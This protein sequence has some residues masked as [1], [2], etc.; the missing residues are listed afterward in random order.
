LTAYVEG[1]RTFFLYPSGTVP[2]LGVQLVNRRNVHR[3]VRVDP[4]TGVPK[5]ETPEQ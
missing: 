1:P 3:I 4:I 5:V 2:P